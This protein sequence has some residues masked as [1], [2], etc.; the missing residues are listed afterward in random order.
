MPICKKCNNSF[1]NRLKIDG[2]YR[3]LSS[4]KYCLDCSPFGLHNTKPIHKN[5]KRTMKTKPEEI[6]CT[7]CGRVYIYDNKNKKGHTKTK[8]NSCLVNIRRYKLKVKMVDYKGGE[9]V[10]CGYKKNIKALT[11]HHVDSNEKDFGLSGSH[12][13]SWNAIKKELDKCILL[14]SN[15]H[16]EEHDKDSI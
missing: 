1:P 6:T 7:V 3:T 14:C 2:K 15:C 12:C 9:C 4:R 13:R 16:I 5:D 10:K 8:C 11:F